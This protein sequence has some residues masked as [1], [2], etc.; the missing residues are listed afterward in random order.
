MHE[1][2]CT[3]V[4]LFACTF[5]TVQ[6]ICEGLLIL[7]FALSTITSEGYFTKH[8]SEVIML[9]VNSSD[10]KPQFLQFFEAWNYNTNRNNKQ[11]NSFIKVY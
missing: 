6:A 3:R 2:S 7:E 10:N 8:N 1:F 9:T 11:E 4:T 5:V